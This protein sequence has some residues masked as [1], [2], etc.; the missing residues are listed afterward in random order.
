MPTLVPRVVTFIF[1]YH[2]HSSPFKPIFWVT[3]HLHEK[4]KT[5]FR[6]MYGLSDNQAV[7]LIKNFNNTHTYHHV[8]LAVT[9]FPN[10]AKGPK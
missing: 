7:I 10:L 1:V 4:K 6:E 8:I 2:P 5:Q 3:V 9:T